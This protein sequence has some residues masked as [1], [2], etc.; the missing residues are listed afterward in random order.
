MSVV[1]RKGNSGCKLRPLDEAY[2]PPNQPR[3]LVEGATIFGVWLG[4]VMWAST[5]A[6]N[7]EGLTFRVELAG[8]DTPSG[9]DGIEAGMPE[10]LPTPRQ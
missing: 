10:L 6:K 7:P 9:L 3:V 8:L 2:A 5:S 4:E 1:F